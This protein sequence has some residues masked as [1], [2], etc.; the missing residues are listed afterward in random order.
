MPATLEQQPKGKAASGLTARHF[1]GFLC[2]N[3]PQDLQLSVML[4]DQIVYMEP[5]HVFAKATV[6]N[7]GLCTSM[8]TYT[9]LPLLAEAHY[10]VHFQ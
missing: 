4:L 9:L 5:S 3:M 7:H 1:R 6:R 8:T 2:E 10:L